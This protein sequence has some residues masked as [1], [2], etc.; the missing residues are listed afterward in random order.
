MFYRTV[1]PF[2]NNIFILLWAFSST[3]CVELLSCLLTSS[4]KPGAPIFFTAVRVYHQ[5]L[6]CHYVDSQCSC[7]RKRTKTQQFQTFFPFPLKSPVVWGKS[8]LIKPPSDVYSFIKKKGLTSE[9][10]NRT[11]KQIVGI[12]FLS[13][14]WCPLNF[15]MSSDQIAKWRRISEKDEPKWLHYLAG[16]APFQTIPPSFHS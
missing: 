7:L 13:L 15:H 4:L 16:I 6:K 3:Y 14:L 12:F 5:L 9:K 10:F 1:W 11:L 2:E 8:N